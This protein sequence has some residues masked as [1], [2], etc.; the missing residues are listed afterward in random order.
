MIN[1][2]LLILLTPLILGVN[3]GCFATEGTAS[4][5]P[6]VAAQPQTQDQQNNQTIDS[7][8][9][10][11]EEQNESP[12]QN[13][14]TQGTDAGNNLLADVF[15]DGTVSNNDNQP[16]PSTDQQTP[17]PATG[18]MPQTQEAPVPRQQRQCL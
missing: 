16:A 11:E 14:N 12:A 13:S 10:T 9:G 7:L 2:K 3:M 8:F 1:K 6:V 4:D 15:N 18:D 17:P 5:Q